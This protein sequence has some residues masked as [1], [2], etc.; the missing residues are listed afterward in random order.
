M[1]NA[2]LVL[3]LLALL[4]RPA[5]AQERWAEKMFKDG[6]KLVTSHDFGTVARGAQL[7]HRFPITNIYA[8][9]MEI[10]NVRTSC[11]CGKVTPSA[12]VLEPRETGYI[13]VMMDARL[14]T[15]PKTITVYVT[16]GPQYTSTAE[17]KVT[18]NSRADVVFNPGEINFGSVTQG[19]ARTEKI[20]VEYAGTLDWKATEV[21]TNG[22]PLEVKLEEWYRR[23]GQVGYKVHATLK[24]DAPTGT[25]KWELH[26]KTNDPAS[27]L[28]PVLVEATVQAPLEV[29]P[30]KVTG[31]TI[32]V[33]DEVTRRVLL[34]G[35]KPFRIVSVEGGG[36]G[37]TVEHPSGAAALHTLTIKWKATK[38][39][40]VRRQLQ[41]KTD[42]QEAPVTVTIEGNVAP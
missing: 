26:L 18:A 3:A 22:A 28:V 32:K 2:V 13:E 33:G 38:A 19:Q 25:F 34:K 24:A 36:D 9:R 1:R 39:G 16:V 41:I 7:F 23:P 30:A 31:G 12:R 27:P 35:N 14:F 8:V 29:S 37:V 40:E 4:A 20:D 10:T 15:G 5:Q 42:L 17:L 11:T 21:A 6:D